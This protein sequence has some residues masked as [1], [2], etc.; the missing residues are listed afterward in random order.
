LADERPP[1]DAPAAPETATAAPALAPGEAAGIKRR[2]RLG[3]IA[4]GARTVA[5]QLIVLGA[6]VWI[7]RLLDP[8]DFGAYAIAQFAM[9]M[10]TF[11]GDA[12][13]GGALVQ[14]REEP[15][16]VALSTV[17]YVQIAM[18]LAV[19]GAAFAL[20]PFVHLLWP[21][22]PAGGGWL[23]RA[24]S[25]S[26]FL[27]T[28]RVIPSIL[29]ER[30]LQ[31]TRLAYLE[32]ATS[33]AFQGSVIFFALHGY[34]VWSL[35]AGSLIQSAVGVVLALAMRP[36]LPALAF[37]RAVLGPMVRFGVPFQLKGMVNFFNM[38]VT[39]VYAGAVLGADR[40]GLVNWGQTTAY[41]P[42]KLIDIVGRVSF[43]LYSRLRDDRVELAALI[44]RNVQ[45]CAM[46]TLFF[47]GL[48]LG[49]GPE[50]TR[51]IF[52]PK[53]IPALPALYIF[54]TAI[55][56]GFVSPIIGAA[57]DALGRP[58]IFV[59]LSIGWTT[60]N[61]L[62]V[63]ITTPLWPEHFKMVGFVIAYCS[64]IVLGNAAVVYVLHKQMPEA[65]L[66]PAVRASVAGCLIVAAV[67]RYGL[68]PWV[69][70]WVTL[71]GA[72]VASVLVFLGVLAVLDRESLRVRQLGAA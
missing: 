6:N 5:L 20:S 72:I 2:A 45:V 25:I 30:H 42:L 15:T 66:W 1:N 70:G 34:R 54:S 53:W 48:V 12:G 57:F 26:F 29:M 28:V 33:V 55:T 59:R 19:V 64:H 4:L 27:T 31:F 21:T 16:R 67:G 9:V 69:S 32:V 39:P 50:L 40:L 51:V 47:V 65:R 35:V 43:P 46:G 23:I 18:G 44:A 3:M 71:V 60:L 62:A 13:L 63:G 49:I 41:F 52:G 68:L 17:F 8:A 14:Q 7:S 38:A 37:D 22:L 56:I 36:F 11:F 24:L 58:G 10:L 61:W